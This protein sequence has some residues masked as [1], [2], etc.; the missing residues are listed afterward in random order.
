MSQA[1]LGPS[2]PRSP[3]KANPNDTGEVY[4][5]KITIAAVI[6]KTGGKRVY[7]EKRGCL[8]DQNGVGGHRSGGRI[9]KTRG[10]VEGGAAG[11]FLGAGK[12][13]E[14]ELGVLWVFVAGKTRR[15]SS[16]ECGSGCRTRER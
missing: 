8:S 14:E 1:S 3:E 4:C 7:K 2:K 13:R 16:P 15:R 12:T 11:W 10:R 6:G 9:W 5:R